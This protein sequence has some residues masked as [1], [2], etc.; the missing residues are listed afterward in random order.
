M[1][2]YIVTVRSGSPIHVIGPQNGYRVQERNGI[3]KGLKHVARQ[4]RAESEEREMEVEG[5]F[6][7]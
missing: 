7:W 6:K 4:G 2:M 1:Y 3:E 5:T